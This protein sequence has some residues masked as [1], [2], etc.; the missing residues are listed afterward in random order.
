MKFL[1]GQSLNDFVLS[2]PNRKKME[3]AEVANILTPMAK[4]L[5][6][7]HT[8]R[9]GVVHRDVKPSNIFLVENG[10]K[11]YGVQLIDFGLVAEIRSSLTRV[12]QQLGDISG[13]W[14]Y[15]A[16]E[17]LR[18]RQQTAETDQYALA[19]VAYELLAGHPPFEGDFEILR[20]AILYDEPE[21][22]R[23][24]PESANAA[25]QKALAKD[26][27][28]R[29]PSCE[30][31]IKA[32]TDIKTEQT[33]QPPPTSKSQQISQP[34]VPPPIPNPAQEPPPVKTYTGLEHPGISIYEAVKQ[35]DLKV[36]QQWLKIAPAIVKTQNAKTDDL[37]FVCFVAKYCLA[38]NIIRFFL[39]QIGADVNA[40]DKT[41]LKCAASNSN[42]EVL[43]YLV[44]LG[45]NVNIKGNKGR[46]LLHI[47][48][49][50]SNVKVLEY[51][52]SL[53]ADVNAKDNYGG[54]LLDS[55]VRSN[56][57]V[58][59][60]KCLVSLGADVNAKSNGGRTPLHGAAKWNSN[61]EVL[62][63]LVSLGGDVNVKDENGM[64]L[65]HCA[66]SNPN[67]EILKYLVSLGVDVNAKTKYAQ[68]PFDLANSEEK[69]TYLKSVGGKSGS[70]LKNLFGG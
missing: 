25:L 66:A 45:G 38:A 53:G 9:N 46:I 36:I 14:P 42:V 31:F 5:D 57:N 18:G 33:P 8:Y 52:A 3:L 43:K 63:Y 13:T 37:P 2:G 23:G 17:Q 65:L 28:N 44:S 60:L 67:V 19:V 26:K 7:A 30:E 51:L 64:T 11:A 10:Q 32:L 62:K 54:T 35:G 15:M 39:E 41:L 29:Y 12:S 47:A 56:S 58:E 21:L 59:V 1:P 22:I 4:A 50:N 55:A 40:K 20:A 49:S 27:E 24:I 48:V 70:W 6:Y 61:M 68:T 16:P 34:P 69:K